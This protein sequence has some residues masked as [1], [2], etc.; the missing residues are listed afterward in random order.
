[1]ASD[2]INARRG[3]FDIA[4]AS[5]TVA[6]EVAD[7]VF[8]SEGL[9]NSYLILT[10]EG[11]VVVNTGMGFEAGHHRRLFDAVDTSPIRYVLFT[12]GHVDHVG[13]AEVLSDPDTVLV[14]Q[15]ANSTCQADDERIHRFRVRRSR[16]YWADAIA[17][18]DAFFKAQPT[19]APIAAQASPTPDIT[20]DDVLELQVGDTRLELISTPGGETVDSMVVWIPHRGVALVGNVFSALFGHFPNLVTL[21]AD[22][23]R[24][25][26][27]F[28]EAIET[29][30]ALE[31]EVLC[32]GHFE[33]LIGRDLIAMELRRLRDAV[34][35]VHDATVEGMNAGRS[36]EELMESVRLPPE[37]EVGE[38]YGKI[39]WGVRA[40]WEGY[41]GW[42]H[43]RS[44]T[45]LYPI[46][47]LATA[48]D[49][50]ELAGGAD[51]LMERA[52]RHVGDGRALEAI[53]LSEIA[54]AAEPGHRGALATM[55]DAH[56]ALLAEHGRENFWLTGWL[57]TQRDAA[58][59]ALADS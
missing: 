22:R 5:S 37:L 24:F 12:Q 2:A 41:A 15:S 25:A 45:E 34:L 3:G 7:R 19:D 49:L 4:P 27:P 9:S 26:L 57:E 6:V 18:A 14:A 43:G 21:R 32:T 23:L 33:P 55:R 1:M 31:P 11:R 28:V 20:F 56:A 17:K 35:F 46:A 53:Q 29:V 10:S 8:L 30:L 40:I 13:G 16:P 50:A 42:F 36:V 38:G 51:R 48:I 47:P 59:N 58:A 39:A 54:L 52:Q 44:T